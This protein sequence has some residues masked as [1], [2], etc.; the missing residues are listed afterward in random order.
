MRVS[1]RVKTWIFDV[2]AVVLLTAIA[3]TIIVLLMFQLFPWL[4]MILIYAVVVGRYR[5]NSQK[6][7]SLILV[8][9]FLVN[10]II[11]LNFSATVDIKREEWGNFSLVTMYLINTFLFVGTAG[12]GV[13]CAEIYI[14]LVGSR[15]PETKKKFVNIGVVTLA[16]LLIISAWIRTVIL[17]PELNALKYFNPHT[18]TSL[19]RGE[20]IS[21][22]SMAIANQELT[23]FTPQEL[24]DHGVPDGIYKVRDH[25]I[26]NDYGG[27]I[28]VYK[29]DEDIH[30]LYE[31]MPSGQKCLEFYSSFS[32]EITG[33]KVIKIDG[34]IQQ[35]EDDVVIDDARLACNSE[36]SNVTFEF[37]GTVVDIT[38]SIMRRNGGLFIE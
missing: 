34:Q 25:Q 1:P 20:F 37:I 32:R 36:K 31:G 15:L 6:F 30:L 33:F 10:F 21:A 18:Y 38:A 23:Q 19:K 16:S 26:I 12:L 8:A 7:R 24:I 4:L 22:L 28:S 17:N 14:G 2:L 9:W 13:V 35:A 5:H 11:T 29:K 27:V 3:A